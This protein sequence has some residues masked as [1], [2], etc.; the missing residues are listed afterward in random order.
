MNKHVAGALLEDAWRQ[1]L[2]DKVFRLL[3][4]LAV[5]LILPTFLVGFRPEGVS[6]LF[7]WKSWSYEELTRGLGLPLPRVDDLHIAMIGGVQAGIVQGLAGTV[8]LFFCIAAT[9]FFVPRMMEKGAADTLFSKPVGRFALLLARYAAGVI[10]VALLSFVLVLGMH[11]GFLVTSGHSDPAFLWSALTLTYVFALVHSVSVATAVV[12]RSSIAAILTTLV[13]FAFTGCIHQNWIR[14]EHGA[15]I[16]AEAVARGEAEDGA[17]ERFGFLLDALDAVHWVL[18][19]TTDADFVVAGLRRAVSESPAG[20][21]DSSGALAVVGSPPEFV[22]AGPATQD[23]GGTPA[24]WIARDAAGLER[25]RLTLSRRDRRDPE[26][27]GRLRAAGAFASD[28][29]KAVEKD[30]ETAEKPARSGRPRTEALEPTW[31]RW[32]VRGEGADTARARG[33]LAVED[34]LYEID[35]AFQPYYGT[36]EERDAV[37]RAF[38]AEVRVERKS[39]STLETNAWYARAFGWTAPFRFNACVSLGS[40]LLFVLALLGVARWRLARTDF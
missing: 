7:G 2:D 25:A 26:R 27:D 12:T 28:F 9:A 31:I 35:A 22:R 6:L 29:L 16:Q 13:F 40:S 39:A 17:Q 5:V 4:L 10:F 32:R 21:K 34:Q 33:F 19:K 24:L 15:A 20:L 18:P 14:V 3:V 23:L 11:V 37:L 1:V 38:L 8:G 30:P 36:A